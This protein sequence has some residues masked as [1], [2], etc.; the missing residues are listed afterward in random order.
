MYKKLVSPVSVLLMDCTLC[1]YSNLFYVQQYDRQL[2]DRVIGRD[3]RT[4]EDKVVSTRV[5]ES[6][7]ACDS[8]F[9]TGYTL[10]PK[11]HTH[12]CM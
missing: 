4:G 9:D 1:V 12:A 6:Y 2:V 5:V 11:S 8:Q 3:V 10:G 7:E